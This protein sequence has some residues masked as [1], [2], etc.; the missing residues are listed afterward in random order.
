M[1][2]AIAQAG[3][4]PVELPAGLP[5]TV[6]AFKG[7]DAP[8][9]VILHGPSGELFDTGSGNAPAEAAGFAA[10]KNPSL[11]HHRDRHREAGGRAL[12]GRDRGG[13]LAARRGH[14]GRR[15][16]AGHRDRQGHRLRPRPHA[17]LH[18]QEPPGRRARRVRRGRRRRRRAAS[19][20]P[21]P[22]APATLKFH[23]AGGA[24]G[25]RE[26]Q[27]VVYGADG[28]LLSR[29]SLG[30]YVAPAPER[31]AQAKK[32]TVKRS[33]KKLVLRWK[34]SKSAYT[35]QVDIRSASGLNATRTV[36]KST[37]SIGLLAAGTKLTVT[38][39]GTTRSGLAGSP[40]SFKTKVPAVKKKK[41]Q[42]RKG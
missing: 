18:G 9:H 23:P 11:G 4:D 29:L 31:P 6:M 38:V 21:R 41:R 30:K 26:I 15:H 19:A 28:F 37:T 34:G 27:A 14:P 12:D 32:L 10:L 25:K 40:A 3:P 33:G 39:T 24:P 2:A 16:H 36:R 1:K 8:P 7:A 17:R 20:S 5:G 35:Q 13:L 42:R 22:T